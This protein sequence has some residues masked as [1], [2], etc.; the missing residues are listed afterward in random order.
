MLHL[1]FHHLKNKL[2]EQ[3]MHIHIHVT[4]H[5]K[6]C[7]LPMPPGP[8]LPPGPICFPTPAHCGRLKTVLAPVSPSPLAC[9]N[10]APQRN[11]S[12]EGPFVVTWPQ[13]H[14]RV[15]Q[16]MSAEA[17]A[18]LSGFRDEPHRAATAC[19]SLQLRAPWRSSPGPPD[20]WAGD[21][22]AP[23]A[24]VGWAAVH[25]PAPAPAPTRQSAPDRP[26]ATALCG[27]SAL[28]IRAPRAR[29]RTNP[30]RGCARL[31]AQVGFASASASR[32]R[33]RGSFLVPR[34]PEDCIVGVA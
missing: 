16:P 18:A 11:I 31:S 5:Y 6:W 7:G 28:R 26:I 1:E 24:S 21:P 30:G 17:W 13:N 14:P 23:G 27:R 22:P 2:R 3:R 32:G 12:V 4:R 15:Q 25:S 19:L 9:A 8:L 10:R 33:P 29:S 34:F 20:P